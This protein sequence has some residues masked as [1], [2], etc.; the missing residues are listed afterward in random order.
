MSLAIRGRST[1]QVERRT[2][3]AW[4]DAVVE[5][6]TLPRV[7]HLVLRR[8]CGKYTPDI[9]DQW[10]VGGVPRGSGESSSTCDWDA[11]HASQQR[12]DA[13]S[14]SRSSRTPETGSV[15]V[16]AGIRPARVTSGRCPVCRYRPSYAC[17]AARATLKPSNAHGGEE[18]VY[19]EAADSCSWLL[20]GIVLPVA[21]CCRPSD[22]SFFATRRSTSG[23]SSEESGSGRNEHGGEMT[24]V[25]QA[26]LVRIAGLV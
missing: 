19:R 6:R 21:R 25:K 1:I 23:T 20:A 16:R 3:F 18:R 4:Q 9:R 26:A 11:E 17:W 22:S 8:H 5:F 24:K 15:P 2:R 14:S 10:E 13:G 7:Y 12:V